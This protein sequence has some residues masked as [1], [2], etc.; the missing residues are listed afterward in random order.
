M[1]GVT[2]IKEKKDARGRSPPHRRSRSA[3]RHGGATLQPMSLA[4]DPGFPEGSLE[5]KPNAA[6]ASPPIADPR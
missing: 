4:D 3:C 1:R 5:A 6:E 2:R